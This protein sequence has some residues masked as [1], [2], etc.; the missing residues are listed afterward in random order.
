MV[1]PGNIN[2][3]LCTSSTKFQPQENWDLDDDCEDKFMHKSVDYALDHCSAGRL[4]Q[5][6]EGTR[7]MDPGFVAIM[8]PEASRE[9]DDY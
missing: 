9:P 3:P 4:V 7:I 2:M 8:G 5:M 1:R 6:L